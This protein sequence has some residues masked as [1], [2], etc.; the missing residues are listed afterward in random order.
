MLYVDCKELAYGALQP[1]GVIETDGNI[2]IA[3]FK[4]EKETAPVFAK[5]C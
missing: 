3:R 5:F 2:A 1:R 4:S